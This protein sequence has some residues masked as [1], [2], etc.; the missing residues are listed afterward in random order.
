MENRPD[1]RWMH[2]NVHRERTLT[3]QKVEGKGSKV[4]TNPAAWDWGQHSD[5]I[6]RAGG[7]QGDPARWRGQRTLWVYDPHTDVAIKGGLM[8]LIS[9]FFVNAINHH[10]H[11]SGAL[12]I[13][14]LGQEPVISR[15]QFPNVNNVSISHI[16]EICHFLS[17]SG[18]CFLRLITTQCQLLSRLTHLK[19]LPRFLFNNE[20]SWL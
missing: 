13:F 18:P 14:K 19:C 3:V 5:S 15:M 16:Q 12:C 1:A 7:V 9:F 2:R 11:T 6:T 8:I 17:P 10:R 4:V 20:I